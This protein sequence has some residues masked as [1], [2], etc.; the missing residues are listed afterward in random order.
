LKERKAEIE[1]M[2]VEHGEKMVALENKD[3]LI[4]VSKQELLNLKVKVQEYE[5]ELKGMK[6]P[7]KGR[8]KKDT[9][10]AK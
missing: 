3:D 9:T 5:E 2:I 10:P 4:K 7:K 6:I 1:R 8:G